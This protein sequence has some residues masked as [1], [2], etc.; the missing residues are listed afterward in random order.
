MHKTQFRTIE[1]KVPS[2]ANSP[3]GCFLEGGRAKA[4]ELEDYAIEINMQLV[5]RRIVFLDVQVY[6]VQLFR[7]IYLVWMIRTS[8]ICVVFIETIISWG[9]SVYNI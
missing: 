2:L 7:V 8:F 5:A 9:D 1:E 3:L 4:N 6:I